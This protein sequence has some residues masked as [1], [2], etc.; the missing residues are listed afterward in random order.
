MEYPLHDDIEIYRI[1]HRRSPREKE[2][3]RSELSE[4]DICNQRFSLN[5]SIENITED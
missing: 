5:R 3:E 4:G 1:F 2:R